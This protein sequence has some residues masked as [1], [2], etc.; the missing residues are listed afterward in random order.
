MLGLRTPCTG[1][2][3]RFCLAAVFRFLVDAECDRRQ[4]SMR[5]EYDHTT[6]FHVWSGRWRQRSATFDQILSNAPRPSAIF[7]ISFHGEVCLKACKLNSTL[8][9]RFEV[10]RLRRRAN[11]LGCFE[12]HQGLSPAGAPSLSEDL[13][14]QVARLLESQIIISSTKLQRFVMMEPT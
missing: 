4:L 7:S 9:F 11:G 12:H 13:L 8:A 5:D 6:P 1:L 14:N 10:P 3:S 2:P